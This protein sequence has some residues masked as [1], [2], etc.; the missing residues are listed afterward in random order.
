MKM[1]VREMLTGIDFDVDVMDDYADDWCI[2]YCPLTALTKDGEKEFADVLDLNVDVD[3]NY[4]EAVVFIDERED[5]KKLHR[6]LKE[7]FYALAGYCSE[8][9]WDKWFFYPDEYESS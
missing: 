4:S 3:E 8:E 5:Y 6:R 9:D 2:A 7:F 1:K